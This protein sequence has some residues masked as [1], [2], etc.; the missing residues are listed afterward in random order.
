MSEGE[1]TTGGLRE[2]LELWSVVLLAVA[3]VAT[4]Y[5]AYESTR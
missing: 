4:A 2:K 5:S 3:M 1:K